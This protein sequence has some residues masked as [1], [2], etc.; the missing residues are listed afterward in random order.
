MAL[1][2]GVLQ[3]LE[4]PEAAKYVDG[5]AVHWYADFLFD[6][7]RLTETH[8]MHPDKFI[9]ASEVSASSPVQ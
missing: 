6:G 2:Q 1:Y 7:S 3:I 8:N 4:D 9:L 5:S